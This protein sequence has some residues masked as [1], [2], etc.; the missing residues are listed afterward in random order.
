LVYLVFVFII[1]L[2]LGIPI[3]YVMG[4]TGFNYFLL[5]DKE[6]L[7]PIIANRI[8]EGVDRFVLMAIPFFML[9]G[10]IMNKGDITRRLV[11][12]CQYLVGRFRGGLGY[13]NVMGSFLFAGLTG[14]AIADVSALGSIFIPAMEKEG[15]GRG[16]SAAITAASSIMGPIIPPSIIIV[17]YGGVTG[18]SIGALFAGALI[19]GALVGISN[20]VYN[21]Y[22]SKKRKYPVYKVDFNFKTFAGYSRDAF[23][24]IIAP[25]IIIGGILAGIFTPTEAGAVAVA[26]SLFIGFFVFKK[27]RIRDLGDICTK[28]VL[29][30]A[31]LFIIIGM[32][33]ILGWIMGMEEVPGLIGKFMLSF[34]KNPRTIFLL[35][36]LLLLFL[37]T[38]MDIGTALVLLAPMLAPLMLKMGVHPVHLG[39]VMIVNLNIGLCTPP[40]GV[41]LFAACGI[42]KVSL[43]EITKEIFPFVALEI[44]VLIII[45]YL[46]QT[47]LYIPRILGLI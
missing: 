8:Y 20:C 15:Y 47:V 45:T 28:A 3:A 26:Y 5:T 27:L 2:F 25:L 33:N 11:G 14:T 10:E 1:L 36:N 22:I 9:A 38:W 37:G 35:I 46:P 34:S 39:I 30:S 4:L 12:F 43:E 32:A 21:Y 17:I 42:A 24:A 31:M 6:I 19:P 41:C 18:T 44:V 13:V 40:L 7:M 29:S 23:L 16:Y